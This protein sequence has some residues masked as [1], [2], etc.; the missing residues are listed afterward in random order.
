[1]EH[2]LTAH[3]NNPCRGFSSGAYLRR[4]VTAYDGPPQRCCSSARV[5]FWLRLEGVV[6][7][8]TFLTEGARAAGS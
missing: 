5:F 1:M 7:G 8:G 6:V 4:S 3:M 2:R